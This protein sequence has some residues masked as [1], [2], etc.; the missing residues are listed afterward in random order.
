VREDLVAD[1]VREDFVDYDARGRRQT[2]Q[3]MDLDSLNDISPP[4]LVGPDF[5][6]GVWLVWLFA[7]LLQCRHLFEL[8]G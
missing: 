7:F 1:W 2:V 6:G 8:G 4:V 3:L 5:T